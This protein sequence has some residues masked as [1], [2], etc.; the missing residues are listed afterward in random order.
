MDSGGF[1]ERRSPGKSW[2]GT[3]R[4]TVLSAG[5]LLGQLCVGDYT[6]LFV[7]GIFCGKGDY[8]KARNGQV[9]SVEGTQSRVR[10]GRESDPTVAYTSRGDFGCHIS[11]S[12]VSGIGFCSKN[13]LPH[14]IISIAMINC[15][16]ACFLDCTSNS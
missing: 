1:L 3:P 10:W 16:V 6:P 13:A 12:L 9:P 7:L 2:E 5:L 11:G 14:A 8:K 15:S 4:I